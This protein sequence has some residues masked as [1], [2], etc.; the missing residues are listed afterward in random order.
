MRVAEGIN[1]PPRRRTLVER[2]R[3]RRSSA[4]QRSTDRCRD[5]PRSARMTSRWRRD[6]DELDWPRRG[7]FGFALQPRGPPYQGL[8]GHLL[9][10]R[11][12][13]GAQ[14]AF[15]PLP[16]KLRPPRARSSSHSRHLRCWSYAEARC[17]TATRLDERIPASAQEIASSTVASPSKSARASSSAS[18]PR[19][20]DVAGCPTY[21]ALTC[22]RPER[23]DRRFPER[24]RLSG[25]TRGWPAHPPSD[26]ASL[27]AIRAFGCDAL[28]HT[29]EFDEQRPP[30]LR[31]PDRYF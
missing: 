13:L 9:R 25:P 20:I 1:E 7:R 6:L 27:E 24:R 30:V 31:E 28:K 26:A 29:V 3:L 15:T 14:A 23:G 18:V 19:S 22:S 12:L 17:S 4:E 21:H 16:N 2:A 8:L 5:E 11:E 10:C